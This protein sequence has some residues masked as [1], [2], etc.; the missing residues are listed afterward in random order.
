MKPKHRPNGFRTVFHTLIVFIMNC[1][2]FE[3]HEFF[4]SFFFCSLSAYQLK[5]THFNYCHEQKWTKK[6]CRYEIQNVSK[7]RKNARKLNDDDSANICWHFFLLLLSLQFNLQNAFI[8]L[9]TNVAHPSCMS[10]VAIAIAI[11]MEL[12]AKIYEER[13]REKREITCSRL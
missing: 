12:K 13:K 4:F 9:W 3:S 11:A 2:S 10:T 1:I 8:K 5:L 7:N 6:N